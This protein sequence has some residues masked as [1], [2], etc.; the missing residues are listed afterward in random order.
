MEAKPKYN[1]E[2][3]ELDVYRRYTDAAHPPLQT[4]GG[5]D[6]S[7][8]MDAW[9][10]SVESR[11]GQLHDDIGGLGKKVD[12]H[13][14]FLL[15]AFAGGFLFLLGAGTTAYFRLDGKMDGLVTKIDAL[16]TAITALAHH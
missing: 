2:V 13:F 10:T 4:G 6:N 7:G 16:T 9:Q 5:G 8:G 1:S 15:S 14:V 12:G 11:L 3:T